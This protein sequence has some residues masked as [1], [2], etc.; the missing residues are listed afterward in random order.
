MRRVFNA[1]WLPLIGL[2]ISSL[3]ILNVNGRIESRNNSPQQDIDTSNFPTAEFGVMS[4]D[5]KERAR[6]QAKSKKYNKKHA[7]RIGESSDG[8]FHIVDW[9]TGLPAFPVARSA[10]IVIGDIKEARAYLSEDGTNIY[11]E[12]SI[13]VDEIL[14]NDPLNPVTTGVGLIAEREGGRVRFPSGKT[15]T[16][17]VNHQDMPRTGRR[18]VFF[19]TR[20]SA[21]GDGS[22][23]IHLLTAYELREG[24]VIPLDK[25]SDGHPIT[26]YK[27]RSEQDFLTEL[28]AVITRGD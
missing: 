5:A 15:V 1:T 4:G 28:R 14:K 19:L 25:V 16:V 10:A 12:F 26:Q 9:D 21:T 2:A 24:R 22:E 6:W 8:I 3:I 27:G 18:Y 11:S 20:T 13:Q 7:P 23:C 17:R